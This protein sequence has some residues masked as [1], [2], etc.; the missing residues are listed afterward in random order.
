[1]STPMIA[2]FIGKGISE[3]MILTYI[4]QNPYTLSDSLKREHSTHQQSTIGALLTIIHEY[5]KLGHDCSDIRNDASIDWCMEHVPD[6]VRFP[7]I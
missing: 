4:R 1:M 6:P 5:G 3:D 2:L 7:F